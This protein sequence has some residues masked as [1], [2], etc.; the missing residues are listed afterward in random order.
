MGIL[1]LLLPKYLFLILLELTFD[2]KVSSAFDAGSN[3]VSCRYTSIVRAI[4]FNVEFLIG[5][6]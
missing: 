4:R 2:R 6:I 1:L 3:G 5:P